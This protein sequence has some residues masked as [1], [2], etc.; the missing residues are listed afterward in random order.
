[1]RKNL[2]TKKLREEFHARGYYGTSEQHQAFI[3]NLL[4]KIDELE[5]E[6]EDIKY[7]FVLRSDIE[8]D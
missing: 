5:E 8:E 6:I 1:M 4:N 2:T 7:R 3:I